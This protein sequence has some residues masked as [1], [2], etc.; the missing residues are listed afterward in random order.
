MSA[1]KRQD[2]EG[3]EGEANVMVAEALSEKNRNS[4]GISMLLGGEMRIC[5]AK[6]N[7][8]NAYCA[9]TKRKR[10]KYRDEI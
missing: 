6:D 5:K 2:E 1:I 4:S 7:P 8:S 10:R 9:M 3:I